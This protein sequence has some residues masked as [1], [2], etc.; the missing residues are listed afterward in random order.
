MERAP[1]AYM[2]RPRRKPP[3][4]GRQW[5]VA[6]RFPT[7]AA[8][9]FQPPRL[10]RADARDL[11][12]SKQTRSHYR[13]H[14]HS[15]PRLL[16]LSCLRT[17]VTPVAAAPRLAMPSPAFRP[18]PSS[19]QPTTAQLSSRGTPLWRSSR[20][21]KPLAFCVVVL[22]YNNN[23]LVYQYMSMYFFWTL[24]S[25]KTPPHLR[26]GLL[27][28]AKRHPSVKSTGFRFRRFRRCW[29]AAREARRFVLVQRVITDGA[30]GDH[31]R[32]IPVKLPGNA[33]CADVI[34][35]LPDSRQSG[36]GP[37]LSE[38]RR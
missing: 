29:R 30:A 25:V 15:F 38:L 12:E 8:S 2:G 33:L 14:I 13:F 3:S 24:V 36:S 31:S 21:A 37:G 6:R 1:P 28:V 17:L 5:F 18:V 16:P 22:I 34:S 11:D 23:V 19:P 32:E 10:L 26:I 35:W 20:N 9:S 7:L 27:C 4:P